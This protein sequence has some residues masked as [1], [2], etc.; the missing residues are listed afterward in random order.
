MLQ[1]ERVTAV[2]DLIPLKEEW[3]RLVAHSLN[4]DLYVTHEWVSLWCEHFVKD[5]ELCVLLVR[6]G[7]RL[8]GVA[9][10]MRTTKTVKGL[11]VRQLGFLLNRCNVRGNFVIAPEQ[12]DE[13]VSAILDHLA[14]AR[15]EWDILSLYGMSDSSGVSETLMRLS[16]ANHRRGWSVLPIATWENAIVDLGGGWDAYFAAKTGHHR[17]RAKKELQILES[18]GRLAFDRY[19]A[20][21]QV[22]AYLDHFL[23]IEAQSWKVRHGESLS[24][25][26]EFKA[27]YREIIR[28]HAERQAWRAWV[29][30][31]DDR[32]MATIFGLLY[33]GTLYAEKTTYVAGVD[34]ASPGSGVIR[35]AIEQSFRE[36]LAKEIDLDQQTHFTSRWQTHTRRHHHVEVFNSSAYSRTLLGLKRLVRL[37]RGRRG[38]GAES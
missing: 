17:K 33:E 6:D 30:K 3:D 2:R 14:D 10:L 28:R 9:P 8:V 26:D 27:F 15:A 11:P 16:F 12:A 5:G 36:G 19:D 37:W 18:L 34:K 24:E 22:E 31:I 23:G 29:L 21:E 13:C 20:P 38:T 32:P 25:R 4:P 1:I 35:H 7:H